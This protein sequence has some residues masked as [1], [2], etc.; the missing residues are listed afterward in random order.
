MVGL[1][2]AAA[3]ALA[4]GAAPWCRATAAAPA[5]AGVCPAMGGSNQFD[6]AT[7]HGVADASDRRR[8]VAA[9]LVLQR[10][11]RRRRRARRAERALQSAEAMRRVAGRLRSPEDG[12][13]SPAPRVVRLWDAAASGERRRARPLQLHKAAPASPGGTRHP[14]GTLNIVNARGLAYRQLR[15]LS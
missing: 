6:W 3:L 9:A 14:L 13:G 8:Q 10:E 7:S 15:H 12:S 4:P 1:A 11:A 5:R 2:T